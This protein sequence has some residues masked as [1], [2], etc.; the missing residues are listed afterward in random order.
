MAEPFPRKHP[1]LNGYLT[2][3][4]KEVNLSHHDLVKILDTLLHPIYP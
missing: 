4:A 3:L 1:Q 2:G